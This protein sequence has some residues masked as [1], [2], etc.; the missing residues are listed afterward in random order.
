[1]QLTNSV[2]RRCMLC[3]VVGA[4]GL[5][6]KRL[7]QWRSA[8]RV[9]PERK[10]PQIAQPYSLV[11]VTE[12]GVGNENFTVVVDTGSS[13]T[14]LVKTGFACSKGTTEAACD[15]GK[16]Y[17]ESSTFQAID[18]ENYD[19]SYS[20][21]EYLFGGYGKDEVTVAG[22][23]VRD[24]Q[25]AAVQSANWNGDG[26]SS[27]V[28]GLGFPGN[29]KAY[30]GTSQLNDDTQ[31]QYNPF[32]TSA[33]TEGSVA[34]LFSLAISRD[35]TGGMLAI[36]GLPAVAY[37]PVFASTPFQLLTASSTSATAGAKPDY[38]FYTIT[39]NGF[40]YQS[41][42]TNWNVGSWLTYFGN[43]NDA[44]EVQ[45][46]IDSGT[47]VN[48]LPQ[49]TADRVNALFEPAATYDAQLGYYTVDCNAKAPEF[50]VRIGQEIF[51][52]NPLDNILKV[53]ATGCITGISRT[54]TG[55]H[56]T[57][58]TVFLKNVLAVFDVGASQMRFAAR[59]YS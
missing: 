46:I 28:L 45:V 9:R 20:D 15:F 29:T 13:D 7:F 52:I 50:G 42:Q 36:G 27:G 24:Q 32:F 34:P 38:T 17:D 43:P 53:T 49:V 18:N 57:L 12:I 55:G 22:I 54:G 37:V 23:T 47:T 44:S 35:T 4:L 41:A 25:I 26:V 21:G 31:I 56:S 1:M 19:Q 14:W 39:T 48:Y 3:L 16:T 10:T 5:T 59:E 30:S 8:K 40:E 6:R 2:N 51:Y 58:G 11:F 33:T